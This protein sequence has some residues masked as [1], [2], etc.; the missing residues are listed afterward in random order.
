MPGAT[1]QKRT[2]KVLFIAS[3]IY[4][5]IKTGGLGDVSAALPAALKNLGADVRVLIPGYGPVLAQAKN[6]RLRATLPNPYA[7]GAVRLL[8]ATIPDSGV[9]LLIA[10]YAPFYQRDGGPYQSGAGQDW[11]DNAQRFALLSHVGAALAGPDS[12]I[13]WRPD[14]VHCNDWQT[15]LVPAFLRLAKN[16]APPCLFTLHNLAYQG[17]FPPE[18]HTQ[19]RL[20]KKSF[21]IH[22][23]EYYGNLSF[24]KAGLFYA[25]HITTVSPNYAREIQ[26]EDLGFGM[27]GLLKFRSTHL[28]GILNGID[29]EQWNPETDPHLAQT[30]S[31]TSLD[32]KAASKRAVQQRLGL[33]IDPDM[34]LLGVV[35]RITHQKGLDLLLDIAP[36][37]SRL[38]AQIA[39]LG[40]G[41]RELEEAFARLALH[42]PGRISAHIGFDEALSHQIEAGADI[43]LMPSRF[44]P[45][46]LNQMYSMHYGTPPVVHA[47]GGLADTVIDATPANLVAGKATGF[48]FQKMRAE[49]FLAAIQRAITAYHDQPLWRSIQRNGMRSNFSWE[50]SARQ[51]LDIYRTLLK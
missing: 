12:P 15:G 47:T 50:K 35:S 45:C 29:I 44:E 8:S 19:L 20:P 40:S 5:L 21:S 11:P 17:I 25:D 31:A 6:K 48:T 42:H 3:E 36:A 39:L 38:P 34:P 46:G 33:E 41:E 18:T 7:S 30:Y 26:E 13:S 51:Y 16:S 4:P 49:E 37:L 2:L 22:G 14:I 28:S 24:L 23:M 1:K 32:Q 27:H 9:P 10:D 43:F